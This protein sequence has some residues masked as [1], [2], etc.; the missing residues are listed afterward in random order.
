MK[1]ESRKE[2]VNGILMEFIIV[3][4]VENKWGWLF[5]EASDFAEE[6]R[7]VDDGNSSYQGISLSYSDALS[8]GIVFIRKNHKCLVDNAERIVARLAAYEA[9]A[10]EIELESLNAKNLSYVGVVSEMLRGIWIAVHPDGDWQFIE[11]IADGERLNIYSPKLPKDELNLFCKRN[12]EEYKEYY[13]KN[14][15][16]D[17]SSGAAGMEQFWLSEEKTRH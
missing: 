4:K 1:T 16:V 9:E 10:E 12:L 13:E 8:E 3:K 7:R 5:S 2:S 17:M 15:D 11:H 14:K 6:A